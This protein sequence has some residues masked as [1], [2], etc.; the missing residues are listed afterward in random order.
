[1]TAKVAVRRSLGPEN[2]SLGYWAGGHQG[3]QEI[4]YPG[5]NVLE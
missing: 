2:Q 3:R 5:P 4:G 1:M